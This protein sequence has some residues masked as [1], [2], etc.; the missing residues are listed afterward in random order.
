MFIRK[1][2]YISTVLFC[3]VYTQSIYNSYGLG[4]SRT[5]F[6]TAVSGAGSIGLVPTFHPGVS[7]ENSATWPGLNFSYINSSFGNQLFGNEINNTKNQSA[8][9]TN[10]QFIVPIG[11]RFAFGLSLKPVNNHNSFFTS[12]TTKFYYA[13][14]EY[15]ANKEFRSGGG[16]MAGSFG[17]S[18]PLNKNMGI[19]LNMN[20]L[21][22][23]SRDEHAMVVNK[24]YYRLFNIRTYEGSTFNIDFAGQ[25]YSSKNYSILLFAKVEMTNEPVSGNL[26]KFDLFEDG[27]NNYTF[28]SNDYPNEVQVDTTDINDIY[29]PN[30]IS[31][32]MNL[33]M[34]NNINLFGEFQ[35]WR[36]KATNINYGSI[37]KEQVGSKSHLGVGLIRFGNQMAREWQDRITLRTG[38]YENNYDLYNESFNGIK[39]SGKTII[40]NGL[41]FGF[42]FKFAGAGNQ[43]DFSFRNGSRYINKN[44]KENFREFGVGISV[45]DVWF[46]RRRTKQ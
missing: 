37:F 20:R 43:I 46:L 27:N 11:D 24:T 1:I 45:G 14:N 33:T 36:D 5:S 29:A 19:G 12:D 4:L 25:V 30:S 7:L 31:L 22:G 26:Y 39:F 28:D 8:G 13:S 42:G 23:S 2:V 34:S 6:N 16:I 21:F 40:E 9:F 44:Y 17:I 35:N 38:I 32:G 41:S 3:F 15:I 10:I 18:L